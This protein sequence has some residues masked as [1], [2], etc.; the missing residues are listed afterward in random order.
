MF[1]RVQHQ[2]SLSDPFAINEGLRQGDPLASVAFSMYVPAL[3]NEVPPEIQGIDLRYR[4]DGGL[5]NTKRF[6]SRNRTN[7]F[8][9]RELQ[10]ADDSATPSH[11]AEDLQRAASAFN[12]AYERFGMQVNTE[13]TKTLF[14]H[15][16]GEDMPNMKISL[17][18]GQ[19]EEVEQFSYLGSI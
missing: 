4:M 7:N 3:M 8:S 15:P 18:E 17:K 1:G 6:R 5:H 12:N 9:V 19:L 13:K 16:P 2:G 10:Y 11:T 14:Q